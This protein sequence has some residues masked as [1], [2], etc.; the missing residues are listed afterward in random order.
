[1]DN[2]AAVSRENVEIIKRAYEAF[3]RRDN[4]TSRSYY[5]PE[6]EF[7]QPAEEPG[8]GTYRGPDG[9]TEGFRKWLAAW[10]D[11]RVEVEDLSD[12]GEHV[13][14]KTRHHGRGK[15]SGIEVEQ[16]I[17]QIW[18]LRNGKIVRVRMYYDEAEALEAAGLPRGVSSADA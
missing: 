16:V 4:A 6:V 17:F 10:D 7:S 3:A 18:T 12:V 9:V 1:M 13:L 15:T 5:D 2:G 11:Y 8:G 14:A